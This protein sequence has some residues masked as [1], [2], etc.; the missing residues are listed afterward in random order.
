M[1]AKS[2]TIDGIT[3]TVQQLPYR[4][5]ARLM[6]KLASSLGPALLRSLAGAPLPTSVAGAAE[7]AKELDLSNMAAGMQ[8]L[9]D[10]FSADDFDR[11]VS[12]L[13][14]TT[15]ITQGGAEVPLL[16]VLD[17]AMAGKHGTMLKA[18]QFALEVNY[19]NFFGAF[20]AALP[21]QQA[22]KQSQSKA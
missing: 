14:E 5:S 19:G 12:E 11:L 21:V 9:F 20:L 17:T 13:F 3:F 1:E 22:G 10:R 7:A 4:K 18:I 8:L 15:T 2:K 16:P 6:H